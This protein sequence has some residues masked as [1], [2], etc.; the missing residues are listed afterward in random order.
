MAGG[1]FAVSGYLTYAGDIFRTEL[2]VAPGGTVTMTDSE[3]VE[4]RYYAQL[5]A[6][7]IAA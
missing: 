5:E 2:E 4:E 7:K 1:H 6:M 3:L